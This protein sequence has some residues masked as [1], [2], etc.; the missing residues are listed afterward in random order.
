MKQRFSVSG[1]FCAACSARVKKTVEE[2]PG[3]K[4]AEVNLIANSMTVEYDPEKQSFESICNTVTAIGYG[5]GEYVY[6]DSRSAEALAKAKK[7]FK[8]LV[9]SFVLLGILMVFSMQHMLG[10]PLPEIF[11]N[12]LVMAVTQLI[13]TVPIIT[14]NFGYFT[15]GFKNLVRFAPNMDSLIALGSSVS[16]I[17]SFIILIVFALR[18]ANGIKISNEHLYFESAAMILT[19]V[20]LGKYLE[21]KGKNRT[22]EAI[23]ALMRLAPKTAT[24]LCDG[25]EKTVS[26][27]SVKEGDLLIAKPGDTFAVDGIVTEGQG[28]VDTSVITGEGLPIDITVGDRVTA[29]TSNLNGRIVYRAEKVGEDTTIAGIIRLVE[30]AGGSAAPISRLAD[31]ISLV[32][33]PAVIAVSIISAIIWLVLGKELS[34][35]LNMAVSVLVISCP[36]ALGLATPAAIMAGIGVGAKHG[37]LVKSAAILEYTHKIDTVVFDKTGTV[38]LGKPTVYKIYGDVLPIAVSLEQNSTHPLALAVTDYG[39]NNN[40]TP[41]KTENFTNFAGLGVAGNINGNYCLGGNLRLMRE[42]GVDFKEFDEAV[43]EAGNIGA[44]LLAFSE[45]GVAK[46]V[47]TVTDALKPDSAEAIKKLKSM[48]KD[49][50]MLTGDNDSAAKTVADTLKVDNYKAGVLPGDKETVIRQLQE[51]GHKVAMIGDG[52]NDAPALTRANVG[53][54]IGAGTDIATQ[55]ADIILVNSSMN[56]AVTA[57]KLGN[58]VIG[59]IKLSLFW[60]FFYNTCGIPIAAGALYSLGI[61]LNPMIAAA[62]MSLSSVCVVLNALRLRKF[63][64]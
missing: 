56:D 42:N 61:M 49:L 19:L 21:T 64:P 41:Y 5:A 54:A 13:L 18:F 40:I 14:L 47:I 4:N 46:G 12:P 39:K 57:F 33:V 16:F 34:F 58:S 37:I 25:V 48:G 31:K 45:N 24:L 28:S 29:A 50:I 23:E 43:N 17:Y 32:F 20:S 2:L 60:A 3:V 44:T 26:V 6:K 8:R 52:I 35:A 59:N 36:C 15:R 38:T 62:A 55:S 9:A 53:I 30:E 7:L 10:Y 27:T 11:H 63:K 1:M 51:N 22:G